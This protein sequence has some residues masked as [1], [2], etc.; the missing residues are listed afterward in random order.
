M[1][2]LLSDLVFLI[3]IFSCWF[4]FWVVHA[5]SSC[6]F[7]L[8]IVFCD[9]PRLVLLGI[10]SFSFCVYVIIFSFSFFLIPCSVLLPSSV[11]LLSPCARPL[12]L[13]PPISLLI[14]APHP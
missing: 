7:E 6:R 10:I 14:G 5:V 4:F 13:S 9:F 2:A 11:L 12:A 3:G 8:G 1:L